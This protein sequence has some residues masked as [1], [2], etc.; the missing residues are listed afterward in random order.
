MDEV[1]S[2][3]FAFPESEFLGYNCAFKVVISNLKE[4]STT[5]FKKKTPNLIV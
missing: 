4:D 3:V 1:R 5:M 2:F